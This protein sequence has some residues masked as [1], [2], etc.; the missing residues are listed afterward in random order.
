MLYIHQLTYN[1]PNKEELFQAISFTVN[2]QEKIALVGHNG[3]GKST[4]LKLIAGLLV[5][6][7]GQIQVDSQAYYIP[8]VV[9]QFNHLS[10]AEALHIDHQLKALSEILHGD[11]T[12]QNLEVLNDDWTIEER[13]LEA[14]RYWELDQFEWSQ[15]MAE[16]SGGQKTK[17]FLAGLH[18]HQ[19]KFVLLDEPTNH[20]DSEARELVYHYIST[21]SATLIVVSHDRELLNRL[22]KVIELRSDGVKTY[23]GNYAFYTTQKDIETSAL[24][25]D[26][27]NQEKALKK[28]KEKARDTLERQQ[29]LDARGKK[30]QEKAGISTIMMNTLRNQAEKTTAKT[31]GA[32]ADKIQSLTTDLHR[33]RD[34]VASLEEIKVFFDDSTLHTG[35]LLVHAEHINFGYSANLL[36]KNPMNFQLLS[37][38]R[39]ALKGKNGAGKTTFVQLV[40]GELQPSQGTISRHF[41]SAM[42]IDQE[43]SIIQDRQTVIQQAESFNSQAL[44][45]HEVK[46]R[47]NRFLFSKSTWD[48]PCST[49]SGGEKLRLIL[50]CLTIGQHS[51][52]LIILDEP[53]NNLDLQNTMLLTHA[54]KNYKGT[55]LVISHDS[56]F[57]KAINCHRE[58][59][60]E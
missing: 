4:L 36:W 43:Y 16:L 39:V 56:V 18:I 31:K 24:Q 49:L 5:P 1:H 52:D 58:I 14:L 59:K 42:Y 8:Q 7:S 19:P 27:N 37:G 29:K 13:A 21:T 47:L 23:G 53:T 50:C 54:I 38:D 34:K 55:L 25:M 40:L 12:T 20:L 6:T 28:A 22:N 51:P 46:I 17:V 32:H 44:A 48:K 41:T 60:I 57:L 9:G 33:L 30:K 35:K 15:S 10:L 11:V 2:N 45:D 3:T 26:M